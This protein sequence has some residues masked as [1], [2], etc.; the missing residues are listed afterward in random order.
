MKNI[1]F[2]SLLLGVFMATTVGLGINGTSIESTQY[3]EKSGY[4]VKHGYHTFVIVPGDGLYLLNG[5]R[6]TKQ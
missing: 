1:D 4:V 2:K 6:A 3:G 5:S